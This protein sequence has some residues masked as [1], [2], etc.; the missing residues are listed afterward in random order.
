MSLSASNRVLYIGRFAA[1]KNLDLLLL[2]CRQASVGISFV[3][4]SLMEEH[5]K[6]MALKTVCT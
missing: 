1:E 4:E 3:G 5:I 6:E 2:T